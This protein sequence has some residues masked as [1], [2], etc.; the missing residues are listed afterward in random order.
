MEICALRADASGARGARLSR[1]RG[2]RAVS[3]NRA[4]QG[5]FH[6]CTDEM[7]DAAKDGGQEDQGVPL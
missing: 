2:L 7:R 6:P 5:E 1:A 3:K 4:A